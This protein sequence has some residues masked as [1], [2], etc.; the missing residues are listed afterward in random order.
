MVVDRQ[1]GE[2]S[3]AALIGGDFAHKPST[4]WSILPRFGE[5]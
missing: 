3:R 2:R 1:A 5:A 4:M